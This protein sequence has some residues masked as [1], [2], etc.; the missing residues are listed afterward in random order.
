MLDTTFLAARP[1]MLALLLLGASQCT[2]LSCTGGPESV[3]NPA[4]VLSRTGLSRET[5]FDAIDAARMRGVDDATKLALRRMIAGEGYAVD[6]RERAF[7]LLY[8]VDRAQLIAA[9]SNSLPKM[10]DISWRGRVCVLIGERRIEE[11]VPTL[12][13]AWAVPVPGFFEDAVRPERAALGAVV[14][15]DQVSATLVRTMRESSPMTQANLR[16]R[17]WELLMKNGSQTQLRAL[18]ADP[19]AIADDG[20]LL[21]IARFSAALGP[22]PTTREEILWVRKR[23]E[24]SRAAFFEAARAATAQMP[25]ARRESLEIRALPIAQAASI[26]RPQLLIASESELFEE[27]LVRTKE[28]KKASPDF[29]GYGSGFSETLYE[30]RDRLNWADLAG[31]VLALDLLSEEALLRHV[32]ETADRDRED[33]T[34]EYGGVIALDSSARGELLEFAPRAKSSDLRYESPQALFDALYTGLFH[35]HNHT[36]KY[37]NADF[38]GPHLGDFA[39]SDSARCNGLVFTFLSAD[40]LD[41]DFYRHGQVVVDLGAVLRPQG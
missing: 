22:L 35:C 13:R 9:M 14:G 23:C 18:L 7:I 8:E 16:A 4:E 34:T 10:S 5:Y 2:L 33:R 37:D 17:C 1:V 24:P 38:S 26:R 3:K 25:V 31:M 41:V 12:I 15:E 30:Q 20:M 21:D 32:F 36:Q 40:L 28:R 19:A 11:L 27:I 29:T 39:F 6:A